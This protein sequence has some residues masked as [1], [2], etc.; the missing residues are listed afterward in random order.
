M[1]RIIAILAVAVSASAAPPSTN[2]L[3]TLD[4]AW[5]NYSGAVEYRVYFGRS[6]ATMTNWVSVPTNSISLPSMKHGDVISYSAR[7]SG[8]LESPLSPVFTFWLLSAP[9]NAPTVVRATRE[10]S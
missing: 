5:P 10:D 9:T 2:S 7:N 6:L 1:R 4:V 8:G 3:W